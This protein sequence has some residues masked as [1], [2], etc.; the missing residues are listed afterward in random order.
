MAKKMAATPQQPFESVKTSARWK[1]RIIEKW[2]RLS[3][4]V[5]MVTMVGDGQTLEDYFATLTLRR[6][7][8][9]RAGPPRQE[10][11]QEPQEQEEGAHAVH[12]GNAGEVGQFPECGGAQPPE[13]ERDAV[14]HSCR[15]T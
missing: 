2:R 6:L 15:E 3:L 13:A 9:G 7:Q 1:P 8:R 11:G 12:G 14:E 4:G 10:G 5:V